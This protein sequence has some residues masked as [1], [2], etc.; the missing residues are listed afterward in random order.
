MCLFV[1][2]NMNDT[3]TVTQL[4]VPGLIFVTVLSMHYAAHEVLDSIALRLVLL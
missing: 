1:E 4:E 3:T 2:L